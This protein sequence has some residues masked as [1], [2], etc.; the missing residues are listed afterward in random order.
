MNNP[1]IQATLGTSHGTKTYNTAKHNTKNCNDHVKPGVHQCARARQVVPVTYETPAVSLTV[2]TGKGLACDRGN[3]INILPNI[4]FACHVGMLNWFSMYF[5]PNEI[6]P[7]TPNRNIPNAK[8]TM[9]YT[10][11]RSTLNIAFGISEIINLHISYTI[12]MCLPCVYENDLLILNMLESCVMI[13]CPQSNDLKL[14]S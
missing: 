7:I 9:G 6:P 11:V 8:T 1:G 10:G 5:G 4:I 2:K 12:C 13:F 3:T 14:L